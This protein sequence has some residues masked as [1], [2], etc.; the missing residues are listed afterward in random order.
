[1]I[2]FLVSLI[3][4][5]SVSTYSQES[6]Q[7]TMELLDYLKPKFLGK[8]ISVKY[9]NSQRTM[10]LKVRNVLED[11]ETGE[12]KLLLSDGSKALLAFQTTI[13][14]LLRDQRNTKKYNMMQLNTLKSQ[15]MIN[16]AIK[17]TMAETDISSSSSSSLKNLE[18]NMDMYFSKNNFTT[19]KEIIYTDLRSQENKEDFFVISPEGLYL[20]DG[21]KIT[22][23]VKVE[24]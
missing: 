14:T 7:S 19:T 13:Q 4:L 21:K 17:D 22:I 6:S 20:K 3:F 5:L 11:S 18:E 15:E 16:F 1:M 2:R 8:S 12:Y 23:M 9:S 24:E 10:R